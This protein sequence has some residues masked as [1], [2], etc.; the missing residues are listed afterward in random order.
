MQTKKIVN[1]RNGAVVAEYLRK[2]NTF[3]TRLKGL[4]GSDVLHVNHGL[5]II[6]C[7]SVHTVGMKYPIDVVFVD[8][9]TRIKKLV[10]GLKPYRVCRSV[11]GAYSVIE[12]PEGTI[13][14]ADLKRGDRLIIEEIVQGDF[15]VS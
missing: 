12:L 1:Q 7:K 13:D 3:L 14:K 2:A 11:K 15:Y 4:L 10:S 5:W 6:P 9:K 8:R